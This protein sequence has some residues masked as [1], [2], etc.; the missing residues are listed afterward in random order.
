[1]TDRD[2]AEKITAALADWFGVEPP[3]DDHSPFAEK[4][5][6][7][8]LERDRHPASALDGCLDE[9][10]GPRPLPLETDVDAHR[11]SDN[12]PRTP[13]RGERDEG[14]DE[15]PTWEDQ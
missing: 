9:T 11:Q 10:L 14:F 7:A 13:P 6:A 2:R 15:R 4:V 5:R 1:M 12:P 3:P 8:H